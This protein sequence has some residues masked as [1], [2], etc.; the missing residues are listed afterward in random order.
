MISGKAAFKS[1][2]KPQFIEFLMARVFLSPSIVACSLFNMR[3]NAFFQS[4]KS[5][6]F[7]VISG[8]LFK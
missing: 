6:R 5:A 8:Y 1:G 4:S 7:C 2:D 3:L